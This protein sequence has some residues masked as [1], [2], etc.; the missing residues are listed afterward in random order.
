MSRI[1]GVFVITTLMVLL[2]AKTMAGKSGS[3]MGR[4]F[5]KGKL[6]KNALKTAVSV[7]TLFVSLEAI[8]AA[9]DA[10]SP[11]DDQEAEWLENLIS[12]MTEEKEG[13][14]WFHVDGVVITMI[15]GGITLCLIMASVTSVCCWNKAKQGVNNDVP[16]EEVIVNVDVN[17]EENGGQGVPE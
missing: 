4:L 12:K 17:V 13:V 3:K 16:L 9:R 5:S 2:Y 8:Q 6:A 10:L 15:A 7:G 1:L 11:G 14:K